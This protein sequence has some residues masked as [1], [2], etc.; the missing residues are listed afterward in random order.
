MKAFTETLQAQRSITISGKFFMYALT[1]SNGTDRIEKQAGTTDFSW[2]L[3]FL[4]NA[5]GVN[6][7]YHRLH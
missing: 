4:A 5:D 1:C 3:I 6:N 7:A 2:I